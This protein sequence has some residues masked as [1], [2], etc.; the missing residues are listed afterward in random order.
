MRKTIDVNGITLSYIEKNEDVIETIFFIHGNS[1][2]SRMWRKQFESDWF[3]SYRLIAID[4]PGHGLSSSSTNPFQDYSPIGTGKILSE[5]VKKLADGNL[6]LFVGFSYG[7][8]LAVEMLRCGLS[9]V[10]I[11]LLG[12]SVFGEGYGLDK[13]FVQNTT[14]SI[15]L[16]NESNKDIVSDYLKRSILPANRKDINNSIDDYLQVNVDFK[17]TLFKTV[18]DGEISDEIKILRQRE[19]PACIIFGMEDKLVN[20]NYLDTLP[21]PTWRNQIY[22]VKDAGHYGNIDAAESFNQLLFDYLSDMIK[23]ARV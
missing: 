20:I 6:Y 1:C 12:S 8:N 16:Y 2:S 3:H 13:I 21:F 4:L 11:V 7:T 22:K 17:P 14:P 10:G 19:I 18:A 9:P 23:V 15:F 5:A